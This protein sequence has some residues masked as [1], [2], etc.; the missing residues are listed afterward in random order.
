MS[1]TSVLTEHEAAALTR[2]QRERRVEV[3][4]EHAAEIVA[5]AEGLYGRGREC[6]ARAV[7]FSGGNDSTTL[8]YAMHELGLVTH[9]VHANTG[10]GIEATRQFVRDT[11]AA[12]GLPLIEQH[13]PAGSR[14]VDLVRERGF[15]GPA[16]HWKMY[17]RL[18]ERCLDEVRGD[19]GVRRSRKRFAMYVAGRRRDESNRRANVPLHEPDGSVVW[20]SPFAEWR[21]ADL[22]TYRLTRGVPRNEVADLLHMSGE[23]LCGS[24]AKQDELAMIGDWFPEVREEIEA[25]EAEIADR[26]DIE[27]ERRKWGW[28]AY[29]HLAAGA[30]SRRPSRTGRLCS[31]CT[32]PQH[33]EVG[34]AA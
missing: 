32:A 30:P 12:L 15:P 34:V 14:F 22:N 7:L 10:I 18:K 1:L 27:P 21:K 24:F 29:K 6:V 2:P 23:C 13:P 17:Q 33:Q 19:L 11:S 20:A 31:S 28:G 26:A 3:L 25:L 4:M 8:L 9:T 16:Q 5:E